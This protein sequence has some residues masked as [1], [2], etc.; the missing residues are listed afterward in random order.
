[1]KGISMLEYTESDAKINGINIDY[2]RMG[3][4]KPVINGNLPGCWIMPGGES[5][6][7]A[8]VGSRQI[9]P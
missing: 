9:I 4:G 1:M 7:S 3:G 2:Y 8:G 5:C 6:G